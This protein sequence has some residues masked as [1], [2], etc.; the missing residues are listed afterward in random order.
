MNENKKILLL[1]FGNPARA[2]DGLGPALVEIIESKNIPDVTVEAN[3]QLAIEDA[4]QIAENNIVIFV[5]AS[6]KDSKPFSFEPIE[7]KFSSS[8][9]THTIEPAHILALAETLFNSKAKG[10]I[11]AIRGY[12]FDSFSEGLSDKAKSNLKKAASFIE[13][14]LKTKNFNKVSESIACS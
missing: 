7:A 6:T 11:L 10:F 2:D 9:S 14:L 8:F 3:Y 5:D 4:S 12:E 1:G 13:N